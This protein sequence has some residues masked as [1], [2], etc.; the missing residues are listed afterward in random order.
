MSRAGLYLDAATSLRPRQLVGRLRRAVPPAW[1]APRAGGSPP[2]A[3][4]ACGGLGTDPAPQ[5]G[6]T[7]PPHETATFEAVGHTRPAAAADLFSDDSDGLLFGF[8]LHGFQPLAD[9]A[10]G[11]RTAAGDAF[12]ADL[13]T[14]WLS[15]ESRPSLPAWH[16]Y[17]TSGRIVAWSAALE[18]IESFSPALRDGVVRELW[19]QARYLGRAIEHDIGGNHVLRNA[20]ALLFAG[21][22]FGESSLW[23]DGLSLLRRELGSQLLDDGGHV[24][25]STSYHR[26]V[27]HDLAELTQLAERRGGAEGWL[28]DAERRSGRW[29]AEIAGPDGRLPLLNDAWEG[30]PV[31]RAGDEPVSHLAASGHLVLRHDADQVV[32]DVGAGAA[33][34]L[35]PHLHADALSVVAWLDGRPLLVDPGS[36]AYTGPWRPRFRATSAHNTVEV[37]GRDQCE[38]WG[39]FR[40]AHLPRVRTGPVRR[41]G[42]FTVAVA[43]HDGYRRLADP[44]GH[45]RALV[46][47]PGEGMVL[48]DLLRAARPHAARSSL[49]LA[50]DASVERL[51]VNVTAI[52]HIG[53]ARLAQGHYAPYLGTRVPAPVLEAAGDVPPET[54]FGW[55]LLRGQA[56]VSELHRDRLVL[57]DGAGQAT[58][59]PLAWL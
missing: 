55:S 31:P 24:E 57:T 48:V 56:R 29:M 15:A 30:P 34:H 8:H 21:A 12:W 38:F 32:F 53:T 14:R 43:A 10:A 7:P 40:A 39:D 9:Y 52:G 23:G 20:K 25:R 16:P 13:L 18:A 50:P 27:H 45:Q 6:P 17:P 47:C 54:P 11:P 22:V 36:Y 3:R 58:E 28:T 59:I 46:W 5:S 1:L 33:R 19:R 51:G 44:V 35:P 41:H 37:D 2:T 49:H 42:R 4:A 26:A